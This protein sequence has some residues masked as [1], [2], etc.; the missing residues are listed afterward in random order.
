MSQGVV[1]MADGGKDVHIGDH[2]QRVADL[3]CVI[4][5]EMGLAQTRV[6]GIRIAALVHDVGKLWL[7][8]EVL[9]KPTELTEIEFGIIRAHAEAG[10]RT[11]MTM[12]FPLPV[13][14][15][16]LQHHERM[17]G[18]GYPQGLSGEDIVLGA[19]ILAVA[20]VIGAMT[21]ERPYRP[22]HSVDEALEQVVQNRGT[23][24]DPEVVDAC[25]QLSG[26]G[27]LRTVLQ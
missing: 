5:D 4:A 6:C 22:A 2:Q 20:D 7:R 25:L 21:S 10:Y 9:D 16:V 26:E 3:A 18:S 12:A 1:A 11:C 19:R 24:Y 13:A 23:L 27:R 17:D 8:S 14:Q 15:M